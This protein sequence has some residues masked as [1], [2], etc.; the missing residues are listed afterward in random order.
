MQFIL[1]SACLLG[2]AVRYNGGDNRCDH[3]LLKRWVDEGRVVPV[4]P[5]VAGGLSTPRPPAEITRGGG[6]RAVVDG[7]ARVVAVD[8]RDVTEQFI[9]GAERA[10]AHAREMGI[11]VAVLKEGSPSCGSGAIYDGNFSGTKVAGVGV[12]T[13]CLAQAGVCV[14]SEHQLADAARMLEQL[15]RGVGEKGEP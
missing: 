14:F 11:R 1:V 9:R 15:E 13:A 5:E 8:G 6:G 4:C 12:T 3:A 7:E 2:E 10:L